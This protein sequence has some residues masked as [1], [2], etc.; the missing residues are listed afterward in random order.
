MRQ[1]LNQSRLSQQRTV[2]LV[3]VAA[4]LVARRRLA[5][6]ARP[7]RLRR[8]SI[9]RW[10]IIGRA[11]LLTVVRQPLPAELN[12][13]T[14]TPTWMKRS[15]KFYP[16][17]DSGFRQ[18]VDESTFSRHVS[19]YDISSFPRCITATAL[20]H[21]AVKSIRQI[22]SSAVWIRRNHW[23]SSHHN[24]F[25]QRVEQRVPKQTVLVERI[26]C[27]ASPSSKWKKQLKSTRT[28]RDKSNW[29][30]SK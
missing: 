8:N 24:V 15:C 7:R 26:Y 2:L 22:L 29:H 1:S 9:R 17:S 4:R 5:I 12:L 28:F 21:L 23:E 14:V 16:L 3:L 27:V 25:C 13:P 20:L 10:Q 18:E 11:V 19:F 30:F 6:R